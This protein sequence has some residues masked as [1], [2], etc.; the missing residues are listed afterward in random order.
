MELQ[1]NLTVSICHYSTQATLALNT[2]WSWALP[3]LMELDG[4]CHE[5]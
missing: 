3:H 4:S 2:K 1:F 5:I